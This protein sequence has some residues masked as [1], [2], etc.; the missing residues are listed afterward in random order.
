MKFYKKQEAQLLTA[1]LL[2]F[3]WGSNVSKVARYGNGTP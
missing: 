2:A 3:S 1:E